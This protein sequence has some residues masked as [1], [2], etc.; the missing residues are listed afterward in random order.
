MLA[1]ANTFNPAFC[2]VASEAYGWPFPWE[3]LDSHHSGP[4]LSHP[5]DYW[6]YNFAI[7]LGISLP[8]G[9]CIRGKRVARPVLSFIVVLTIAPLL[10]VAI[11]M[12]CAKDKSELL[13]PIAIATYVLRG[14]A[15]NWPTY[16]LALIIV[17]VLMGWISVRRSFQ[18]FSLRRLLIFSVSAGTVGGVCVVLPSVLVAIDLGGRWVLPVMFAGAASGAITLTLICL[19]YRGEDSR[20]NPCGSPSGVG[21]R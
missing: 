16:L 13:Y 20:A 7:L 10:A 4:G 6:I 14:M 8:A 18:Q 19:L 12:C 21:G 17:P 11:L 15:Q 5:L 3:T 1:T 2:C 9:L